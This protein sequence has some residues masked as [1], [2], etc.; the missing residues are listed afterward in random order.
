MTAGVGV[1]ALLGARGA[2]TGL[3]LDL[4]AGAAGL[5]RRITLPYVQKTGLALSGFDE[6]LRTGRVLIFGESEIRF[7]ERMT[8]D[9]RAVTLRRLFHRDF[10]CVMITM[11]L[12]GPPELAVEAERAG[13]PLLRTALTTP[14]AIARLTNILEDRLAPRETRHGV[15]MDILGLGVFLTGESGIG[16]SECALDLVVRGH[17]LVADDTVEIRCRGEAVL[18]GTCPEMTR[19]HVEIRGL[20]LVNVT[21]LFG[22]SATRSSKRVE[23]VVHLERWEPGREYERL[24]L[25]PITAEILGVSVPLVTMPVAPGRNVAMLVEVAARNQLLRSRGRHAAQLLAARLERRLEQLADRESDDV[26]VDDL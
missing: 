3:D 5:E 14:V 24:G 8:P 19:H 23:L 18:I 9:D 10:P 25:D 20:G 2:A 15:L 17:R 26:E 13:V 6:Y 4:L 1:G 16:K 22:V 11:G 21:D 7:L 12:D